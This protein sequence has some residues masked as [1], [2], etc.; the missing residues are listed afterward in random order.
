MKTPPFLLIGVPVIVV[1]A[2]FL[3][4][5]EHPRLRR[6]GENAPPPAPS[7]SARATDSSGN[8]ADNPSI[9]AHLRGLLSQLDLTDAQRLQIAQIRQ[10]MTDRQQRHEAI[11]NILTP[12]QRTRFEQLRAQRAGTPPTSTPA[13]PPNG[14]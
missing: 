10:T 13:P 3:Y 7:A 14:P 11:L 12:D 6:I 8:D 2:T 1:I 4:F 9:G 5:I